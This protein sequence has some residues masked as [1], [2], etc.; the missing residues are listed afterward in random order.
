MVIPY[1]NPL[2]GRVFRI[3]EEDRAVP[4]PR[5]KRE[6][7]RERKRAMK[8]LEIQVDL[9]A[10]ALGEFQ[11]IQD[12][13]HD[14]ISEAGQRCLRQLTRFSPRKWA[15]IQRQWRNSAFR[16]GGHLPFDIRGKVFS[17]SSGAVDKVLITQFK[18]KGKR[19]LAAGKK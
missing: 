10:E 18:L 12:H 2:A 3:P 19:P 13:P 8:Q 6:F 7:V 4:D 11:E 14:S 9:T 15:V 5:S 1:P 16:S 17:D